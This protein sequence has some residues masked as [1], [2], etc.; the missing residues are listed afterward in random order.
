MDKTKGIWL[1]K[2]KDKGLRIL[3][4]IHFTGNPVK[5]LGVYVGHNTQKCENKNRSEKLASLKRVIAYWKKMNLS[6][7]A[8]VKVIKA[9]LL[10]KI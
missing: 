7:F 5:C 2:L 4:G 1:A 6:I 10:S 8:R 3:E 9:Y